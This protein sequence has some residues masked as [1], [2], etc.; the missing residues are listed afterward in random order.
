MDMK[1]GYDIRFIFIFVIL[2]VLLV[3][4]LFFD[5][6]VFGY[7]T[8]FVLTDSMVPTIPVA[9]L[10]IEKKYSEEEQENLKQGDIITF[11]TKDE[12]NT[13]R[14]THRI[15]K[16]QDGKIYTKGDNNPAC[17]PWPVMKE[18]VESRVV[19]IFPYVLQVASVCGVVLMN[20]KKIVACIKK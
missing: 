10:L 17:D 6:F 19:F 11:K 4:R 9:S 16:L 5:G 14:V 12:K 13:L 8:A 2:G 7:R 3:S 20:R 15:T 18:H 1:K